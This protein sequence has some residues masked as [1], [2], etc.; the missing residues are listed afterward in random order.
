MQDRLQLENLFQNI[1]RRGIH[2][3]AYSPAADSR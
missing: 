2:W 3:P 1:T